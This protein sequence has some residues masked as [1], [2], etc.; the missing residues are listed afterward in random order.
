LN[1]DKEIKRAAQHAAV[2]RGIALGV[3]VDQA[4]TLLLGLRGESKKKK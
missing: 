2:E 4:L 3:L 1:L